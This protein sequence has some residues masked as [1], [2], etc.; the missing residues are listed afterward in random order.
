[1]S[2]P[3]DIKGISATTNGSASLAGA[4][5]LYAQPDF[6]KAP[7]PYAWFMSKWLY[8]RGGTY[9]IRLVADDKATVS[10]NGG[11]AITVVSGVVT[12]VTATLPAG[13][14]KFEINVVNTVPNSRAFIGFA[15]FRGSEAI[16]EYVT[17]PTGWAG[18]LE[19]MPSPGEKPQVDININLPVFPIEHNWKND[20]VETF[21][22]LTN[23]MSSES[24]AEQRRKV[25]IFP[26]RIM[27][28]TFT[29]WDQDGRT[30]DIALSG[31]GQEPILVPLWFDKQGLP[32]LVKE[33][34]Y[35]IPGDYTDRLDF[36]PGRLMLLKNPNDY[37]DSEVIVIKEVYDDKVVS[38]RAIKKDWPRGTIIYPL[39][40]ARVNE[41]ESIS[42]QT[43]HTVETGVKFELLDFL[44]INGKWNFTEDNAATELKVLTGVRNNW[45]EA[46]TIEMSRNVVIQD[47]AVSN[48]IIVDV[49]QN[50]YTTQRLQM[51]MIGRAEYCQF[52]RLMY[53]MSG[54]F[55]LFQFPTRTLDIKL[56]RDIAHHEGFLAC[57]P[58]G[59]TEFSGE[60]QHIRQWVMI[61]LTS[62][63]NVF[64]RVISVKRDEKLEYLVL[65]QAV[66][67]IM[68]KDIN[69]VCWCPISRLG[70]DS[71]EIQHHTDLNGVCDST[72]AI[73]SFFNR[74]K[75][76]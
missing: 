18:D 34:E 1:M 75:L 7:E 64:A 33:G 67:N 43:S 54:Q 26:R 35:D 30:L 72:L 9:R 31:L 4:Q 45:K 39:S 19:E 65:E 28:A 66:G 32:D 71:V 10:I 69:M 58:T 17:R 13:A 40:R 52:V 27:S 60:K 57:Y 53:A 62:G 44:K 20:I 24:G 8:L 73:N 36:T 3:V 2:N 11:D 70:S 22:F 6:E 42:R 50:T 68:K 46:V 29:E 37:L 16:A 55:R 59:Y 47:N 74:R 56:A 49:G 15:M 21:E 25:R 14:S 12:T 23:V 51:M 5:L 41:V 38:A 61:A 63:R 76:K 48:S